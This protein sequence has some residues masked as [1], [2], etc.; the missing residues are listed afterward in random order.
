M[1]AKRKVATPKQKW[2]AVRM[3]YT[4]HLR[5]PFREKFDRSHWWTREDQSKINPEAA[6]YE[7]ARRHPLVGQTWTEKIIHHPSGDASL[8]SSLYWTCL[9]GL[10]SWAQLDY[11]DRKNWVSSVGYLKGLDFRCEEWQCRSITEWAQWRIID[12]RKDALRKNGLTKDTT[13]IKNA[14]DW[15]M[16]NKKN[17]KALHNEMS[18]NPPTVKEWE[19]AIARRAVE[20]YRQGYLLLAV[21]PDLQSD[22]A[23]SLMQK[24]YGSTKGKFANHPMQRARR[25]NWLPLIS[26]FE[27]VPAS[28][29]SDAFNRYRRV[30]DGIRFA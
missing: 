9:L 20:A 4:W 16:A 19:A 1:S 18:V 30:L 7:L 2:L 11:T 26:E 14:D 10:K 21:V 24:V 17:L 23:A 25:E 5:P 6:L 8:P 27:D 28:P 12:E 13:Y 22:K 3:R 29:K 15:E